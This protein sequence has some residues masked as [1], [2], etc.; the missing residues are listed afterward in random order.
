MV[1]GAGRVTQQFYYRKKTP[2]I[3]TIFFVCFFFLVLSSFCHITYH[4]GVIDGD[5][6]LFTQRFRSSVFGLRSSVT[7]AIV[8]YDTEVGQL[9]VVVVA[10][11]TRD[12]PAVKAAGLT[13]ELAFVVKTGV[14]VCAHAKHEL[15][16]L[17][18]ALFL[19]EVHEGGVNVLL[20]G[21]R[22]SGD[23]SREKRRTLVILEPCVVVLVIACVSVVI[24]RV[25]LEFLSILFV[26]GSAF[27]VVVI[28]AVVVV[29]FFGLATPFPSSGGGRSSLGSS[30]R[31]RHRRRLCLVT[32]IRINM[33]KVFQ[34]FPTVSVDRS[35]MKKNG[36]VGVEVVTCHKKKAHPTCYT[37][38]SCS[39]FT[40]SLSPKV[41]T[42]FRT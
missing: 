32:T 12:H 30:S 16:A 6:H 19:G 7:A 2:S 33:E 34:F 9:L 22:S 11:V 8:V 15:I 35:I 25:V 14:T 1:Q 4:A 24:P 27:I 23:S 13:H 17:L 3:T 26:G 29:G 28:P 41:E 10:R 18:V 38:T 31:H 36:Q 42:A 5:R 21:S 37:L 40:R 20:L 39:P